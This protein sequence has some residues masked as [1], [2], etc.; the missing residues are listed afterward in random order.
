MLGGDPIT[1]VDSVAFDPISGSG[2]FSASSA[3][4]IAYRAGRPSLTRLSWFDRSG[5][6]LGTLGSPEQ[7]GLSTFTLS[8]DGHR[9]AAERTLQ[10]ETDLWLLDSTHLTR[11]THGADGNI[12]RVPVW[13]RDGSRLAFESTGSHSAR[14]SMKRLGAGGGDEVPV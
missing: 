6:A 1:V 5:N 13:S 3:A 8:P 14:L 11:F 4:V 10:N 2:A 7:S 9:V 12:A